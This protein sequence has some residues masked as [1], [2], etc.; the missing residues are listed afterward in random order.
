[1]IQ[2]LVSRALVSDEVV[3]IFK[4]AGL[5]KPDISILSEE[6][7]AEVQNMPQRSLAAELLERLLRDAIRASTSTKP[8]T[9]PAV[10]GDCLTSRSTSIR[11]RSIEAGAGHITEMLELAK[12]LR[13]SNRRSGE[14]GLSE[15][16]VAFYDAL[17]A[18]R[19]RVQVMGTPVLCEIARELVKAIRSSVTI[20]WE[21]KETVRAEIRTRI[22][23]LLR[24]YKYPP[25]KQDAA[26][27]TVLK[28]AELLCKDW[29]AGLSAF[30]LSPRH[31]RTA[32]SAP[33]TPFRLNPSGIARYF[34]LDCDRFLR[35]AAAPEAERR[36][37]GIPEREFDHSPLMRAVLASGTAWEV[38][39]VERLL[40]GRGIDCRGSGAPERA[41]IHRDSNNGAPSRGAGGPV[42]LPGHAE[43]TAAILRHLRHRSD[44]R[45]LQRLPPRPH[46]G[47]GRTGRA[48]PPARHR[49]EAG[50]LAANRLP[51]ANPALRPGA[52]R[53]CQGSVHPRYAGGP[54]NGGGLAGWSG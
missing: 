46:R 10:L 30:P 33:T 25:D 52:G 2:Q 11:N 29:A 49:R 5:E 42:H 6:F 28:Q 38:E 53:A 3:D 35:F 27:E 47:T 51:R 15:E 41:A 19:Q 43:L 17:G 14:L 37:A 54:G 20:D 39:V 23:R 44:P 1:M 4:V 45:P 13:E 22:K 34:F 12:Q 40:A 21:H 32:M 50:R 36:K 31:S 24:R 16:E 48:P 18:Q 8:G 7:L 26:T 9:V